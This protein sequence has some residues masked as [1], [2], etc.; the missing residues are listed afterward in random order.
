LKLNIDNFRWEKH[1]Y[2]VNSAM[3]GAVK[4]PGIASVYD[5]RI[6]LCGGSLASTGDA[7]NSV[8]EA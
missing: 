1:K 7:T 5:G 6:I 2:D 8:Y 4:Y 3:H